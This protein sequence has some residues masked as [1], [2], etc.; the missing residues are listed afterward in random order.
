M[1]FDWGDDVEFLKKTAAERDGR[2]FV[3]GIWPNLAVSATL[4]L[5]CVVLLGQAGCKSPAEH[6]KEADK[7]AYDVIEQKQRE[8]IGN[9]EDFAIERSSDI[10]R[11]R[12]LEEQNLQYS[13][14]W[15]LGS[16]QL[17]KPRH[18]PQDDYPEE[19][20]VA[21]LVPLEGAEPIT[22]TMGLPSFLASSTGQSSTQA[23]PSVT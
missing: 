23:P 7:I 8:A 20:N 3:C 4:V 18:W 9:V 11:R 6:R 16:D 14:P 13:G 2:S 10:L 5:V 17:A 21:L 12:L 15:S 19:V 1:V 22:L